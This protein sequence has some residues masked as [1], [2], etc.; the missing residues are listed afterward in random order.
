MGQ[1]TINGYEPRMNFSEAS[2][3][4]GK[5][6]NYVA[7]VLDKYGKDLGIE[8]RVIN[9]KTGKSHMRRLTLDEVLKIKLFMGRK[10]AERPYKALQGILKTASVRKLDVEKIST[11]IV[12]EKPNVEGDALN[13][14]MIAMTKSAKSPQDVAIDLIQAG[15]TD[16]GVY[17]LTGKK[18][19]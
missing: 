13:Q 1:T 16:A 12:P 14:Y 17:L 4:L 9:T 3:V 11:Q 6:I 15:Y 10:R 7:K 19:N 8:T 5:S 2:R 18:P